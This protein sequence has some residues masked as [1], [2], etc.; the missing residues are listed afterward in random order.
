M[1]YTRRCFVG[2]P[3]GECRVPN[4]EGGVEGEGLRPRTRILLL[5]TTPYGEFTANDANERE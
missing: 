5:T 2:M 3:S 1:R 4:E